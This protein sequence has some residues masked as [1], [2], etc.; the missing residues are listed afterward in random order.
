MS[1]PTGPAAGPQAHPADGQDRARP[2]PRPEAHG[3]RPERGRRRRN[4]RT[5]FLADIAPKA[6]LSPAEAR[7]TIAEPNPPRRLDDRRRGS[8]RADAVTQPRRR[9]ATVTT[10]LAADPQFPTSPPCSRARTPPHAAIADRCSRRRPISSSC[11]N[12]SAAAAWSTSP[13]STSTREPRQGASLARRPEVADIDS[14]P[15]AE[16]PLPYIDLVCEIL[17]HEVAPIRESPTTA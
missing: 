4:G 3:D 16:T 6:G 11:S 10:L 5:R 17:K 9:H 8:T 15:N 12:S 1:G 14:M 7:H 2:R 13:K